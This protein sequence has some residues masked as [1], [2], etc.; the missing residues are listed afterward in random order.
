MPKKWIWGAGLLLAAAI[1]AP[2][3]PE[4]PPLTAPRTYEKDVRPIISAKCYSCHGSDSPTIA[5]FEQ[6][7]EYYEAMSKGPRWDSYENLLIVV[8]GKETGALMRRLDDGANTADGKPGNMYVFLGGSD[9]ERAENLAI[10]KEWV[11]HWKLERRPD[12]TEEDLKA[13][14]AI[15]R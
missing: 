15:E 14:L 4:Q 11:G 5:E 3:L 10:I 9:A 2:V 12:W 8:N 1:A 6:N 7:K 13:V